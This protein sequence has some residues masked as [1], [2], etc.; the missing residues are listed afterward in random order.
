M[1]GKVVSLGDHKPKQQGWSNEELAELYRVEHALAQAGIA[2]E[3]SCGLTDEGD[4]WFVFCRCQGEVLVHIT[5]YDGLYRVYSPALPEPLIGLSFSALTKSFIS[6]LRLPV[7]ESASVSIHP[8][9]L[10][11]VL[12]AAIFYAFDFHSNPAHAGKEAQSEHAGQSPHVVPDIPSSEAVNQSFVGSITAFCGR[13]SEAVSSILAKVEAAAVLVATAVAMFADHVQLDGADADA[14]NAALASA[15]AEHQDRLTDHDSGPAQGAQEQHHAKAVDSSDLAAA[16]AGSGGDTVQALPTAAATLAVTAK[17]DGVGTPSPSAIQPAN[18]DANFGDQAEASAAHSDDSAWAAAA[19]QAAVASSIV[20]GLHD[21]RA[22]ESLPVSLSDHRGATGDEHGAANVTLNSSDEESV[23]GA[24]N[25][26][27]TANVTLSGGSESI[28]LSGASSVNAINVVGGGSLLITG[29]ASS[30]SPEIIVGPHY[31][32]SLTFAAGTADMSPVIK[33]LGQ[34]QLS[35]TDVPKMP[36]TLDS[37]G[38]GSNTVTIADTAVSSGAALYLSIVGMQDLLL[39]ETAAAFDNTKLQTSG[40]SGSLTIGLDLQNAAQSIDLSK[41]DA[42]SYVVGD[43]ANVASVN[44]ANGSHIELGSG[45]NIVDVS[46]AGATASAPGSLSFDIGGGSGQVAAGFVSLLEPSLTSDVVLN[47]SG[48]GAGANMIGT[49]KDLALAMLTLTGDFALTISGI[50]GPTAADDQDVTIDAHALTGALNLNVSDIADT[51]AGGRSITIIGG[52]GDNVLTNLTATES[53]T[54]ILGPGEN[55][56]NMGAGSVSNSINGFTA[57][58]EVNIGPG[59]YADTV[60]NELNPGT[61]QASIDGQ[62]SLIAAAQ[63]AG[64]LA[65]SNVTHEAVLFIYQ[66][67]EYAFI[68]ASG[69]HVFDATHDAIVKLSEYH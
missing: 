38:G 15:A 14:D 56:I 67:A 47:S 25:V 5:R 60:I 4:P 22:A 27:Q 39:Q 24:Q 54:F 30:G 18:F 68:D 13:S 7:R 59:Q 51:A 55:T 34:D 31:D 36:L 65:S 41:V 64:A 66:G 62:T 6:G 20:A 46:V 19:G 11:S 26:V 44:A 48:A 50:E 37:E 45:L 35:L 23:A 40:Y 21:N 16:A 49:L 61:G 58:T 1:T 3:T 10:L 29:F 63:A 57:N 33:L 69:S 52:S 8:A 43:D 17:Q 53:T 9:A 2:L 32:I 42:A 12:V 28:D